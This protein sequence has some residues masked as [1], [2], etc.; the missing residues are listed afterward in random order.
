MFFCK[1]LWLYSIPL[2]RTFLRVVCFFFFCFF[3][4]FFFFFFL[5]I[6]Y[7]FLFLLIASFSV[8]LHFPSYLNINFFIYFFFI[9]LSALSCVFN[10]LWGDE[11]VRAETLSALLRNKKLSR[12][13]TTG[14]AAAIIANNSRPSWDERLL[15]G[16][17][18]QAHKPKTQGF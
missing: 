10:D 7:F 4:L 11:N 9:S 12:A 8:L 16:A 5:F 18:D 3:F 2:C 14:L 17:C 6:F 13:A 1:L 15:F